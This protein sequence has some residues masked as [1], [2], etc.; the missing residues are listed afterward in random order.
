VDTGDDG[1]LGFP[2]ACG[3]CQPLQIICR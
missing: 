2:L 3:L 1:A